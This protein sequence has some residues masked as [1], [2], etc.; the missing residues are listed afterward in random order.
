MKHRNNF[1]FT[2]SHESLEKK[3]ERQCFFIL[4]MELEFLKEVIN[5]IKT[6]SGFSVD[7]KFVMSL[8]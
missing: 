2:V 5:G 8:T 4:E 7:L 1:T 6:I 3:H